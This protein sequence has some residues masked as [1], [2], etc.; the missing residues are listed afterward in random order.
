MV[1]LGNLNVMRLATTSVVTV[2]ENHSIIEA[3]AALPDV[4]FKKAPIV[5]DHGVMV[6][7]VR[8]STIVCLA[9]GAYLESGPGR[10][11]TGEPLSV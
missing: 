11:N 3:V 4:K 8:R 2:N 5:N 1:R 10:Q 9:I 6:G 7:I